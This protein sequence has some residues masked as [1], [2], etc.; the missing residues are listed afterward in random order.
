MKIKRAKIITITSSKGGI[1]KTIF[2]LNLA[3]IYQKLQVKTL[4]MDFDIYA[5]GISTALNLKEGKTIYNLVD[6]ITNNRYENSD[7]YIV[8]SSEYIDVLSS[9]IDPRQG[10]RIDA[11]FIEKIFN[12]YRSKYDVILVDT[13]HILTSLNIVTLDYSDFVL[14]MISNDPLDL[15]NSK[16]TMAIFKDVEKNNVKVV[17]NESFSLDK[18]YFSYFD[19]KTFIKNNINYIIPKTLYI[20]QIDKYVMEGEALTLNSHLKFYSKKDE[21]ILINMAKDLIKEEYE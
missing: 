8:K 21:K 16:S 10:S 20:P 18:G 1:G 5:G 14:Y 9:P 15:A 2:L 4:I 13:S 6:D 12:L 19:I 3:G 11:S 7:E 17:L